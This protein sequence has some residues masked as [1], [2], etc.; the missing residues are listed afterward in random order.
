V[1]G[2]V[3]DHRRARDSWQGGHRFSPQPVSHGAESDRGAA[4]KAGRS[5]TTARAIQ[6]PRK[7]RH[8]EVPAIGKP[9]SASPTAAARL[10]LL[11]NLSV[12]RFHCPLTRICIG[13]SVIRRVP[14]RS[15]LRASA[16]PFFHQGPAM[17]GSTGFP[18]CRPG[19]TTEAR[20]SGAA[21]L[22]DGN[23]SGTRLASV[24]GPR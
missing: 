21:N 15:A 2:A 16:V 18:G 20:R 8:P 10:P 22:A 1:A 19:P 24:S 6:F 7:H 14:A 3:R 9:A 17:R 5:F 23:P 13:L 12:R 4:T 11:S